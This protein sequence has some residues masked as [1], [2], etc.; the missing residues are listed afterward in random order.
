MNI[1]STLRPHRASTPSAALKEQAPP[2]RECMFSD[3]YEPQSRGEWMGLVA[4]RVALYSTPAAMLIG[5]VAGMS[6]LDPALGLKVALGTVAA[7]GAL[8][9]GL[10]LIT[11]E[12]FKD[13]NIPS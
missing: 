9:A 5:G 7:G 3:T 1:L 4:S 12:A 6:T 13:I 8:G 2:A 10:G 11:W